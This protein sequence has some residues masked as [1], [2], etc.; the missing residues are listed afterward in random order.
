MEIRR[1]WKDWKDIL[2]TRLTEW[3]LVYLVDSEHGTVCVSWTCY[4]SGQE[5]SIN[6]QYK[7]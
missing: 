5:T 3:H 1:D 7:E 6:Y 2:E 4:K